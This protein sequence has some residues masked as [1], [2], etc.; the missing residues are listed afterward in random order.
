[1]EAQGIEWRRTTGR[2]GQAAEGRGP[3]SENSL[4]ATRVRCRL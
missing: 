4:Q 3:C 1:M 2:K